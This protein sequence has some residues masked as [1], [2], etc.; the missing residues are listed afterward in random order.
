MFFCTISIDRL[1]SSS[2]LFNWTKQNI[3]NIQ[4][5]IQNNNFFSKK[6]FKN[7]ISFFSTFQRDQWGRLGVDE[8]FRR[9]PITYVQ[10]ERARSARRRRLRRWWQ[11]FNQLSRFFILLF[12]VRIINNKK[13][14][15]IIYVWIK[16]ALTVANQSLCRI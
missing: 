9:L 11:R 10:H 4:Q 1:Q 5:T 13:E 3:T 14:N 15:L 8:E 7:M 2:K 16:F 12:I 6:Y